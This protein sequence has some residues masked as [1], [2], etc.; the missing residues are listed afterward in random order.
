MYNSRKQIN[1][2]IDFFIVICDIYIKKIKHNIECI[3]NIENL[4]EFE[5]GLLYELECDQI[6]LEYE[7]KRLH[8]LKEKSRIEYYKIFDYYIEFLKKFKKEYFPTARDFPVNNVGIKTN[9]TKK[10]DDVTR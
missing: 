8:E 10:G 4:D 2:M 5:E 6:S 7:K 1:R 3:S 9:N